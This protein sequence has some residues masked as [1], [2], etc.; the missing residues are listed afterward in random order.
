MK[1]AR[2]Q[3]GG[4]DGDDSAAFA[5]SLTPNDAG[6]SLTV[7]LTGDVVAGSSVLS[8]MVGLK[9]SAAIRQRPQCLLAWLAWHAHCHSQTPA[10]GDQPTAPWEAEVDAFNVR[11]RRL[12][13][14]QIMAFTLA[15]RPSDHSQVHAAELAAAQH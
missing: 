14:R 3:Q 5:C 8:T 4:G 6:F 1:R 9:G 2:Q 7:Q 13:L 15:Y 10:T 12:M 11:A